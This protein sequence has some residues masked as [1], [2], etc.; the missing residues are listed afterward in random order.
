MFGDLKKK[1]K[2]KTEIPLDLDL[3]ENAPTP[4]SGDATPATGGGADELADFG[5][6][7]KKKKKSGKKA[8][9]DLE[10]FEKELAGSAK[11]TKEGD[12]EDE[13]GA[14]DE[15][16]ALDEGD[17]G[18]DVF[19]QPA[20]GE[21]GAMVETW[22]GTDRDYT[23]PELLGRFYQILRAQNPEL[24]G[25]KRRYTIVPPS[26][27][28]DGNKKTVFANV[29]EICKRMHRQPDHVIQFLFAELAFVFDNV[30]TALAITP[31]TVHS[32]NFE[33]DPVRGSTQPST[34]YLRLEDLLDGA[35]SATR[36][37]SVAPTIRAGE[38]RSSP[39]DGRFSFNDPSSMDFAEYYVEN[40]RQFWAELE[41]ILMIPSSAS[42]NRID[43]ALRTFVNFCSTYHEQYLHDTEQ[44]EHAVALLLDS[45]LFAFHSDRSSEQLTAAAHTETNPHAL[46]VLYS[47]LLH[48]G[49]RN[50]A[51]FGAAATIPSQANSTTRIGL[52]ALTPMV[53]QGKR[54]AG[55][56]RWQGL[57]P[58]LMDHVR[59]GVDDLDL[60]LLKM[61]Y[62]LF[63][64]P[65]THEYFYTNDL[66]VLVDVFIREL[67]NLP[68]E[69]ESLRHTYLRVLHPLV[70][71]TQLKQT[72]YKRP[73]LRQTL[74]S[75]IA[76]SNI[77]DVNPTTKR[78]VERCLSAEWCKALGSLDS[79][80]LE[81]HSLSAKAS[82]THLTVDGAHLLPRSAS[83]EPVLRG[84]DRL[85]LT[86]NSG[87]TN[88]STSSLTD[89]AGAPPPIRPIPPIRQP[90]KQHTDPSASTPPLS[91][92]RSSTYSSASEPAAFVG[93]RRKAPSPPTRRKPPAVPL[94]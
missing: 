59:W 87:S 74:I 44:L 83:A 75:L 16:K 3:D 9:F 2:K 72:P 86:D 21:G 56:K 82:M 55:H 42:L 52:D 66:R 28:R 33:R 64:T 67:T 90:R 69:S 76:H 7:K 79:M 6:L 25:E 84:L 27:H 19:A 22:H 4:A 8:A 85:K 49:R 10:A 32:A 39:S 54:S 92:S 35:R 31:P 71:N 51:F 47:V 94:R 80:R 12:E 73:E 45:D 81:R 61:L 63:T 17:L 20:A 23:Y 77:R 78:L 48:Y 70:T 62:L 24:A 58:L 13:D 1:K 5:D 89:V 30:Y 11:A 68:E 15:V 91:P 57:I 93:E 36:S 65:G 50:P 18:E 14:G 40:A 53:P 60:L 88:G 29:S 38:L 46:L 34:R 41:D 37:G 43:S 26:V